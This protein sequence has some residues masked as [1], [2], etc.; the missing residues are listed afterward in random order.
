M[1]WFL[2]LCVFAAAVTSASAQYISYSNTTTASGIF[3]PNGGATG[4]ITRLVADDIT[5]G[6]GFGGQQV[7]SITFSV[8]NNNAIAHSVRARLRFWFNNGAGGGPGTYYNVPASVGFTFNPF[9]FPVGEVLLTGTI[10]P[11][12]F[13]M[14]STTFWAGITFDNVGSTTGATDADLNNFGMRVYGPPTI[15]SSA[16]VAFQTTAAGSFFPTSNPAGT[17]F[18]FGAGQPAANFGWRFTV[19]PEP[20]TWALLG[21]GALGAVPAYRRWR[22]SKEAVDAAKQSFNR[23]A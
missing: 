21:L 9:L 12:S 18:N 15:G 20:T 5:P 13:I 19:V 7:T 2:S 8:V 10:A 17:L 1:R 3:L 6:P 22:A 23:M 4:G 11:N 14:P 16:D